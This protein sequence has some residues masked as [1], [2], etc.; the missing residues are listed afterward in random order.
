MDALIV[1]KEIFSNYHQPTLK[2]LVILLVLCSSHLNAQ[3]VL[4]K[5]K[6]ALLGFAGVD[7]TNY[8]SLNNRLNMEGYTSLNNTSFSSGLWGYIPLKRLFVMVG[9]N[10]SSQENLSDGQNTRWKIYRLGASVGYSL[11]NKSPFMVGPYLGLGTQ[12][13][14]MILSG[15]GSVVYTPNGAYQVPPYRYNYRMRNLSAQLGVS[16]LYEL[17]VSKKDLSL[18]IGGKIQYVQKLNA[19]KWAWHSTS[20]QL[21]GAEVTGG[22][23]AGLLLGF[24]F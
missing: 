16:G 22:L 21:H 1:A 17:R 20:L 4:E 9:L 5:K 24:A 3:Y 18:L 15:P 11:F 23:Q 12:Q 14:S 8:W 19:T 7:Y 13:A 2:K 10:N 6:V